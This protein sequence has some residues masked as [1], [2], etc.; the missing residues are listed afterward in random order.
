MAPGASKK[1]THA[2]ENFIGT[3]AIFS[4]RVRVTERENKN[5]T[6]QLNQTIL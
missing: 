4:T 1:P 6:G 5:K 2:E 3:D